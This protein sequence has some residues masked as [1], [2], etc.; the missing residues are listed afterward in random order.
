MLPVMLSAR[1]HARPLA[2]L[3]LGLLAV[4]CS[5]HGSPQDAALRDVVADGTDMRVAPCDA[6]DDPDHD[7]IASRTE[8]D[9]DTDHDD[10]PD[11]R[12]PDAD[13]DGIPDAVEANAGAPYACGALPRDTDRDG[14]PDFQDIDANGDTVPDASEAAP[15][16]TAAP[17]PPR[18]CLQGGLGGVRASA[19]TG[20]TCHPVDTDRDG[21]PDPF[22]TDIDDDRIP[23][24]PEV[25]PG[26]AN[27]PSDTDGDGT[28]DYR[29]RDSDGDTIA[30]VHEGA[31]DHD[32]DGVANFRDRD[33]DGDSPE[34]STAIT[35]AREAGD[36][37]L[38]TPPVECRREID[39]RTLD[40]SAPHPDGVP[41]YLDVD[42]DNDGLG[43][44]EEVLAETDRCNPDTDGDGV[45]DALEVAWCRVHQRTRCANDP[46]VRLSTDE[47][48]VALPYLG[49]VQQRELEFSV[50]LRAADVFFLLDTSAGTEVPRAALV[51]ALTTTQPAWVD[52]L[53]EQFGDLRLGVGHFEDFAFTA[54]GGSV[55]GGDGARA[56]WPLCQGAPGTAGCQP[57]WGIAVQSLER[58]AAV[59]ATAL[60][61][62]S[63]DGGDVPGSQIEAL[64]QTLTGDG[65]VAAGGTRA[66]TSDSGRAPCWIP[67]R[68]CPD[69]TRGAP[70]FRRSA[71]PVIFVATGT[72]FHGG[73]PD[74]SSL[75]WATYAGLVPPPHGF[76]ELTSAFNA[77]ASRVVGLN[78]NASVRCES[79]RAARVPGEPCYD[80]LSVARASRTV[81]RTGRPLL[82]DLPTSA[83]V[84]AVHDTLAR[85]ART[86]AREVPFDVTTALRGDVS[87]PPMIDATRF[88]RARTPSCQV[89]APNDRCWTPPAGVPAASAVARTDTS[90]FYQVVPATRVRVTVTFR[91]DN[92]FEGVDHLSVFHLT[93]D[94]LGDGAL[95]D[96]R[97]LYLVIPRTQG[98]N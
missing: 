33:S 28:P 16:G 71:M 31:L 92:V 93:L 5:E 51:N 26:G 74:A 55:Y 75:P 94:A 56:F 60:S 25:M 87:N 73:A 44:G 41:D 11:A 32:G 17:E 83:S 14:T 46:A 84:D 4:A 8:G 61:F 95:V 50:A 48:W 18:D 69:G 98:V 86:V 43:D 72:D 89:G 85:A 13:N 45:L 38:R 67:P 49:A 81:D 66:C 36:D 15:S 39:L 96:S 19:V 35:D 24:S 7:G 1:C 22:D 90:A 6:R 40:L 91:N 80:L 27:V 79:V 37:D 77:G 34:L 47:V 21:T 2:A 30:D 65:L 62:T 29:D 88:I 42:S 9:G 82:F 58:L 70:C 10:V 52:A 97:E 76:S 12:D 63:G 64:Y 53:H 54:P 3:L 23:N 68:T 78:L 20:W 59:Q 57:G